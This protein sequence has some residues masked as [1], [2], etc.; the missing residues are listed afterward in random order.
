MKSKTLILVCL[1]FTIISCKKEEAKI[2]T[3]IDGLYKGEFVRNRNTSKVEITFKNGSFNGKSDIEKFP[4]LCNGAYVITGN[5]LTFTNNCFWTA[6]F[7]WSLILSDQWKFVLNKKVLIL[8]K[9]NG[10]KYSL[11]QQ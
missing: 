6:E 10:D 7:D 11:K 1:L 3:I 5:T 8:R 9:S 4:A 2:H